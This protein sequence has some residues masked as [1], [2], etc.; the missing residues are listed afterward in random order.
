MSS[1]E[2]NLNRFSL[3]VVFDV[4]YAVRMLL[5]IAFGFPIR[6]IGVLGQVKENAPQTDWENRTLMSHSFS[7]V[8]WS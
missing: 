4:L 5:F 3:T 2:G 8:F 7:G 6:K 1:F